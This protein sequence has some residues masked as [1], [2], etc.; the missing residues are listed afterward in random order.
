MPQINWQ[1]T[2]TQ[3]KAW[4]YLSDDTTTELLFGGGAG[5]S[6]T[7]LG[8]AWIILCCINYPGTRWVMA[9]N[10]LKR[11]KETTL[12]TFFE[13]CAMW[14]I[15]SDQHFKYNSIDGSIKWLNGSLLL[16]KELYANPSDPEFD[17]LGSLEIT[18]AFV[19]EA[20]QVTSK[21]I[22]ILKSRIR[23]RLDDFGL[24]PKLLMTCNP[25][26]NWVYSDFYKLWRD[27]KLPKYRNFIISLAKDNPF[28]SPHYVENLKKLDKNSR[29]RLLNGNWDYDDDPTRLF[30]YEDILD[31]FTTKAEPNA[32]KYISCDV[33][34]FGDDKTVICRWEGLQ[35]KE[36]KSYPRTTTTEVI[37]I[38]KKLCEQ[39]QIKR[40]CVVVDEDGVGGGVVDG[41]SGCKGFVNNSR[42]IVTPG[43]KEAAN[44]ANLKTQAYY[45]LSRLLHEGKIGVE[46]IS[47]TDKECLIEELGQVKQKDADKDGKIAL[48]G[49]DIMKESLGRS[50]DIADALMMRMIFE[51]KKVTL[52]KP[53]FI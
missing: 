30:D 41:F 39:Y 38:L 51:L 2:E 1:Q 7:F 22:N 18:G 46:Q 17:A 44:F 12:A 16:L 49:K 29:E 48:I 9:R 8:C 53:F 33:A 34:R 26:K 13:I 37:E 24:I 3:K 11:L 23:Y 19:D 50:P 52:L 4:K 25:A 45:E 47:I 27:G 20:N 32:E 42:P 10:V 15:K 6:K 14:N 5:G 35:C 40:H 28:L 43:K 31:L 36:V 21:G